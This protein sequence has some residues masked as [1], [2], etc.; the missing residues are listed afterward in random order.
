[1]VYPDGSKD[2]YTYFKNNLLDTLVNKKADGT[3]LES[4]SYD[5]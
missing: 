1:V 5:G 4:Y 3:V 2:E